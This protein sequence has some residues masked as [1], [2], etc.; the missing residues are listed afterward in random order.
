MTIEDVQVVITRETTPVTQAGFG[1]PLIVGAK[2]MTDY[3]KLGYCICNSLADVAALV[4]AKEGDPGTAGTEV[5]KIAQKIFAQTPAPE[6]IAVVWLDMSSPATLVEGLTAL[7]AAGHND[8]YFLLSESQTSEDVAALAAFA[9]ANDKLYFGSMTNAAF[10]TLDAA[11]LALDRA[12]ILCHENAATQYPAEAWVGRCAP[13]LPGSITWKFKTLSGISVSGYTPTVIDA[14]KDKHGNVVVSQGGILHT[15]EGT[16]L[17]GEFID[18][19]RSQ[20]WVKA[21][22]AEGVF[23]LLATSPKVPYDDRGIAMVLAE[24]QGVMQQATAQGI[25]ARD[26]DGNGMWS[27]TAPKRS[28]IAANNI[29]KRV[30]PDVKFE[31]TLA[32]AIHR[33]TVRGVISV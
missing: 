8:W 21:R 24:V 1:L 20:D 4:P 29:A 5:Y 13:E 33:V 15:I 18:V 10:A 26:A 23:R 25:I 27:V 17:S 9:A 14:I 11:T 2:G 7:M 6:K 22:I 28:E 30:L 12:V 16:V 31:F 19:I 32:G 3:D